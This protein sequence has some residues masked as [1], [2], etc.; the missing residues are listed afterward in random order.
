MSAK[1]FSPIQYISSSN[2]FLKC[3]NHLPMEKPST[4]LKSKKIRSGYLP[5]K[6][7]I[8]NILDYSKSLAV[9]ES[10]FGKIVFINN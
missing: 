5:R 6:S 2:V 1:N 3:I 10:K 9:C 7:V 8:Q 4:L